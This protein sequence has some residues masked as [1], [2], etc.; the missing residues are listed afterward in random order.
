MS[1]KRIKLASGHSDFSEI[2]TKGLLYVDKTKY[3]HDLI[4]DVEYK[5]WFIAR[6]RRF[7]KTMFVDT[8]E[9]FF[10]GNEELFQ[11]LDIHSKGHDFQPAPVLRL[12][13]ARSSSDKNELKQSIISHLT[14]IAT[15][16][17]LT[18]KNQIPAEALE[19][20]IADLSDKNE[21]KPVV[22]LIDEYDKPILDHIDKPELAEEMRETLRNFYIGLKNSENIL[23]FVF[24]TGI[25]KFAKTAIHSALNNLNDI[26]HEKEYASICG[27]TKNEFIDNFSPLFDNL[28]SSLITSGILKKGDNHK[29][30][31]NKI[32][33]KYNGYSWDGKTRVLN[34]YSI[35]NCFSKN[36]LANF[37]MKTGPPLIL[38][39]V[40]SKDPTAFFIDNLENISEEDVDETEI[41]DLKP[42]SI[43]FQTGYL[44]VDNA[45]IESENTSDSDK[46]SNEDVNYLYSLKIPNNEVMKYYKKSL[47]NNLFP[48]LSN[49]K[50]INKFRAEITSYILS[51]KADELAN[52]LHCQLARVAYPQHADRTKM[53]K[54]EPK[55]GEFFFHSI[56]QNFFDGLGLKVISEAS[57][58]R[59]RSDIDIILSNDVYTVL[60]I[61]Y[62]SKITDN[63]K[64][65]KN[66]N[67]NMNKKANEALAQL[68]KTLQDK[69]YK[70]QASTVIVAGVVVYDRDIVLVKFAD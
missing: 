61:K 54:D 70:N 40:M 45:T 10:R 2:R 39:H 8:L 25:S 9:Q 66:L 64:L 15:K 26:T 37:W 12:N 56:F 43:L 32:L 41:G 30:L 29:I 58:S 27:Y 51:K 1:T 67:K 59:G 69:K 22:V 60:E 23:R 57:S 52:I 13:L 47:F 16:E 31:T 33:D 7:G 17:G 6:P 35:N 38:T 21:G 65:P 20:L 14:R 11:G 3:I 68:F 36:K 50:I 4:S 55:L 44:T 53:W 18:I 48:V 28:L 62:I 46:K 5:Y 19:W 24:V 63:D 42:I 49:Y 34:P